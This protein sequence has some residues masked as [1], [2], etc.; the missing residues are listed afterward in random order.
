VG[1]TVIFFQSSSGHPVDIFHSLLVL[2]DW[3]TY[4]TKP[5]L[6]KAA[7]SVSWSFRGESL[8]SSC[9]MLDQKTIFNKSF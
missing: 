1:I 2:K 4:L 6:P 8:A 7:T 9:G 5:G 3:Y